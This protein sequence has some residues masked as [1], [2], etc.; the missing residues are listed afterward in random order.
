MIETVDNE[1][2]SVIPNLPKMSWDSGEMCE[3]ASAFTRAARCLGVNADYESVTGMSGAAFRFVLDESI[4]NPGNY[5][6]QNFTADPVEP[7]VAVCRSYGLQHQ[8]M[9]RSTFEQDRNAICSSITKGIPVI[10]FGVVGPSDA[11]LITGFDNDGDVLLG[12]STFQ[13]IP[14]DHNEPHDRTGYFRKSEWHGNLR[15]YLLLTEETQPVNRREIALD[16]ITRIVRII[17]TPQ[18]PGRIAG[19]RALAAWMGILTDVTNF[20]ADPGT[21]AWRYLCFSTNTTMLLD[22]KCAPLFLD[23]L[24]SDLPEYEKAIQSASHLYRLNRET[25]QKAHA[26]ISDNF[27]SEAQ[28]NFRSSSVRAQYVDLIRDVYERTLQAS[29]YLKTCV[30]GD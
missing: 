13:D 12:W 11:V 27:S 21:L 6:I 23:S 5:W 9:T 3:F 25:I 1:S 2:R 15:G 20:E 14:D 10:A 19:S 7:V 26:T 16:A 29:V 22:Q 30:A 18:L 28:Q 4:W 17:E 8:T 24:A